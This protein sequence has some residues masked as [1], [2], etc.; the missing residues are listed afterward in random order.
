MSP[1]LIVAFVAATLTAEEKYTIKSK[2]DAKGDVIKVVE[3]VTETGK[4][5]FTVKG[6]AQAKDQNKERS[7]T[8]RQEV[9]DT[10]LDKESQQKEMRLKAH[11]RKSGDDKRGEKDR[12]YLCR[13]RSRDRFQKWQ[14]LLH[15]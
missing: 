8:Y 11:V 6:K 4:M 7:N 3:D 12:A 10:V 5:L 13:Q 9:F 14:T 15:H 2:K 1:I